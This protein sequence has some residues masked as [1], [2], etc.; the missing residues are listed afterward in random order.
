MVLSLLSVY[1]GRSM[2]FRFRIITQIA[3]AGL[4]AMSM[5]FCL[6][7]VRLSVACKIY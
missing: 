5:S 7:F 3:K 4:H 1:S 2:Q 6:L